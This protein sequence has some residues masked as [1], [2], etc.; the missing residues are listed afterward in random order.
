MAYAQLSFGCPCRLHAALSGQRRPSSLTRRAF[1]K[2]SQ[3]CVSSEMGAFSRGY[4]RKYSGTGWTR[5]EEEEPLHEARPGRLFITRDCEGGL[6]KAREPS[7]SWGIYEGEE[8][9]R[10]RRRLC[11]MEG[12]V[13][14]PQ[15]SGGRRVV[16]VLFQ[17]HYQY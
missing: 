1:E 7:C 3:A 13:S 11:R 9:R 16:G 10:K 15:A 5:W 8:V 4:P 6:R 14:K 12:L 2:V 17:T